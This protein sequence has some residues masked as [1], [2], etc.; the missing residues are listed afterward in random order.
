MLIRKLEFVLENCEVVTVE[1]KYVGAF[2]AGDIRK[3]ISRLGCNHIGM[4][5]ICHCFYVELHKD[6]NKAHAPFGD[7]NEQTTAF[8][9]L[10]AYNDITQI[11]IHLYDQYGDDCD[12][13]SKDK[14]EHYLIHWEGDSDYENDVQ[15]SKIA[16]TG[17]FYLAIGKDTNLDEMFPDEEVDDE[18]HA[19]FHA[20]MMDI[21]DKYCNI[22]LSSSGNEDNNDD[23]DY[24]V[25]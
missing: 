25:E 21:G 19:D 6:A 9:R 11:N 22:K 23:Y 12:D 2:H 1:G 4:M 15:R 13:E 7:V 16:K 5:E 20:S 18:E 10:M 8:K 3:E 14:V 17:W 24:D